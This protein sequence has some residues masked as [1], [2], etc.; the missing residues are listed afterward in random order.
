MANAPNVGGEVAAHKVR[1]ARLLVERY[2]VPLPAKFFL[3]HLPPRRA[4]REP[5]V[6][7]VQPITVPETGPR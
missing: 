5:A 6:L 4:E 3:E 1:V 2:E 7:H